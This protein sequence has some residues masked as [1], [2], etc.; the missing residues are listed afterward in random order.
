MPQVDRGFRVRGR[1]VSRLEAFSDAIFGLAI[2]LVIVSGD[3]PNDVSQMI[4][5]M[6][7]FLAYGACFCIL[8]GIWESHF[9]FCRRFGLE[10]PA[11]RTLTAALLFVVSLYAYPL[12]MVF[13]LFFSGYLH[14]GGRVD[15]LVKVQVKDMSALFV[16]YGLGWTIVMAIFSTMY[17][18]AL[19]HRDALE[20]SDTEVR[21]SRII[22]GRYA[23]QSAVGLLSVILAATLRPELA[24]FTGFVYFLVGPIA[25]YYGYLQGKETERGATAG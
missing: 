22:R 5:R 7:N 16:M 12:K 15:S 18:Y 23:A 1:E 3:V 13:T 11:V 8:Y 2:T 21:L 6:Q 4:V 14:L 17:G 9:L 10:S 25:G 20:L 19:W 24:G